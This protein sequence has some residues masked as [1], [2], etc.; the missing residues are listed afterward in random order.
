MEE[1]EARRRWRRR[2]SHISSDEEKGRGGLQ[3][4][5]ESTRAE[6]SEKC[7]AGLIRCIRVQ[8]FVRPA[9]VVITS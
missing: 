6:Q 5:T 2:V 4:R 1:E 8:C 3:I 7:N 9:E